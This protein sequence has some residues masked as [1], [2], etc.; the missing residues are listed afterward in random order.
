VVG[1]SRLGKT[2][3]LAAAFDKRIALAI[4]HQAGCGG[5][6]PSRQNDPK[7]ESVAR[8]NTSFPHWFCDNFKKFNDDPSKLPFDQNCLAALV[9]PRPLLFTNAV[10]DLWANPKGQFD[11]LKAA[12][13]VYKLLGAG[14]LD[15]DE[16]PKPG[17]LIDSTLGYYIRPGIHS[18]T[19]ED[20]RVFLDFA[21]KHFGRT[22][23]K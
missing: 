18:M 8:I 9:A 3:I 4:P 19:K 10:E 23:G 15:A 1:H 21:D 2:A 6:A 22:S 12:E 14:G 17:R 5:T 16:M 7:A 20:W 11:A 13:P